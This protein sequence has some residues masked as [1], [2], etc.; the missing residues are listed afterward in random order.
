MALV[1]LIFV[2][3]LLKVSVELVDGI[4]GEMHVEVIH[5]IVSWRLILLGG[6]PSQSFSM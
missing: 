4:V 6:E 1:I 3:I 2:L 5:V